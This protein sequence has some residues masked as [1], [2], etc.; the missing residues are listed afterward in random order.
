[1]QEQIINDKQKAVGKTLCVFSVKANGPMGT[2]W[3][4]I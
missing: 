2:A 1:M 4:T 3:F